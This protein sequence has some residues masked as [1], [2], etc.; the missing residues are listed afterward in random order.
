M[1]RITIGELEVYYIERGTGDTLLLFPDNFLSSHAYE[2]TME[3]FSGTFHV[4]A[5]DYPGTGRSTHELQ[6]RD[7]RE[8]DLWNYW[9]DLACH[10]LMEL[11]IEACYAMGTGGGA[12]VA[13]HFAGKQ[14]HQHSLAA[15]GIVADSFLFDLDSRALHRSLDVRE[16]YYT[17]R[18]E[19]L[20]RQ[21]GEDWR[22]VVD[23]DTTFLRQLADHGGYEVPAYVLNGIACPVLLTGHLQDP[24]T[25]GIAQQYARASTLIP[26]CSLYLASTSGHP[27]IEYPFMQSNPAAFNEMAH[28]FLSG[29]GG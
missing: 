24:R 26:D 1:P 8:F 22:E 29:T 10:L 9:A 15:L 27:H 5:F 13:L 11:G 25:P 17:R 21:H 7:E 28:A 2:E 20:R 16:H 18:V 6:Y 14:V 12:L 4:L 23:R 19:P 3:G